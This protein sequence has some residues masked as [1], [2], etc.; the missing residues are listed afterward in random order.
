MNPQSPSLVKSYEAIV[1]FG[2]RNRCEE[3]PMGINRRD[4]FGETPSGDCASR[5]PI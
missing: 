2:A 1:R 3:D 4:T 5:Y